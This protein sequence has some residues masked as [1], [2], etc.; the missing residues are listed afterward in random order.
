MREMSKIILLFAITMV[1]LIACNKGVSHH[2]IKVVWDIGDK[3]NNSRSCVYCKNTAIKIS[4]AFWN[5][6]SPAHCN[7]NFPFEILENTD[8]SWVVYTHNGHL[9][10]SEIAKK[11]GRFIKIQV[12]GEEYIPNSAGVVSSPAIAEKISEAVLFTDRVEAILKNYGVIYNYWPLTAKAD[13]DSTW[14]V[15]GINKSKT[16]QVFSRLKRDNGQI[17]KIWYDTTEVNY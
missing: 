16:K 7:E 9:L 8:S 5:V 12:N 11:D 15:S 4:E 6:K 1:L 13:T 10:I 14:L 2:H 3:S 17:L